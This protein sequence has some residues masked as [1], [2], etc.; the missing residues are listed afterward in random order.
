[1]KCAGSVGEEGFV[2]EDAVERGAGNGELAGGAEFVAAVEVEDILHVVADDGVEREV[3]GAGGEAGCAPWRGAPEARIG[4][5]PGEGRGRK[6]VG[7]GEVDG[8]D[9]AVVGFE[10]SGF[11]D[12]GELADV[13]G[14]VVLQEAGKGAG[15]KNDGALLVARAEAVEQELGERGDVFAAQ[16]QRRNGEADG[17]EA[18]GEVGQQKSLAGHLAQRGLRRGEDDGAARR[19]ILEALE[20]AEQQSLSGRG[21]QVDAIEISEAGEGGGIGVG[22]QP[23]AGVAALEAGARPAASG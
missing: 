11:E 6:A 23:F 21:E 9:D 18:E 2:G 20:D 3:G 4:R 5:G 8:A 22:G 15:S 7:Q 17:G 12:A 19:A 1:M 10:Q 14:P 16:A 13:A